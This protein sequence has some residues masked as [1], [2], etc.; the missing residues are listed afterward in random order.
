MCSLRWKQK[1]FGFTG[2]FRD[3][4]QALGFGVQ[5]SGFM[6]TWDRAYR[7]RGSVLSFR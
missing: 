2:T 1:A 7:F 4:V 6:G 3:R 5:G